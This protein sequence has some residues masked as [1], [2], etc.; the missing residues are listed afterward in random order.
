MIS[1]QSH[2]LAR[3]HSTIFALSTLRFSNAIHANNQYHSIYTMESQVTYLEDFRLPDYPDAPLNLNGLPLSI[4]D[5]ETLSQE[6][7][8]TNINPAIGIATLLYKWHPNVLAAFLDL[9]AWFSMT[10][11]LSITSS[12]PSE[13]SKLEIGRIGNQITFGS[14]DAMGDNWM[15]MLTYNIVLEG[16]ERGKWTPNPKESMVGEEDVTDP[17]EIDRLGR[18]WVIQH[19]TE[20]RWETG[21]KVRHRFFVEYAPMDV[22]GDGIAM[23]PHWLYEA[24]DLSRCT[25]CCQSTTEL[26]RCGRCGTATYCSDKCQKKDWNVHKDVCNMSLEERGKALKITEKGGLVA[27]DEE[28]TYAKE[29]GET[30]ANPNLPEA[31]LKRRK[32]TIKKSG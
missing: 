12:T 28:R 7:N 13:S 30:S 2:T 29:E 9:D 15:L 11:S 32:E 25:T 24:L 20:K 14:L 8:T 23:S 3:P 17:A 31:T 27:W 5:T 4:I 6:S 19:V 22:W 26:K 10:W 1:V 18:D 21:K 16:E